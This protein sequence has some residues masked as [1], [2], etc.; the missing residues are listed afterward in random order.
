MTIPEDYPLLSTGDMARR[1]TGGAPL[2][3]LFLIGDT[4][5]G[6]RSAAQAVAQA[7]GRAYPDASRPSFT[8]R[9]AARVLR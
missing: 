2:P 1:G 9:C 7:L 5:G 8:T 6:H 4:G 3:L